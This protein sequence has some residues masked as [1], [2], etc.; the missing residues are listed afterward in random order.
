MR[1]IGKQPRHGGL[2]LAASLVFVLSF[3][4]LGANRAAGQDLG[5]P[6]LFSADEIA[7]DGDTGLVKA[8]GSV[9]VTAGERILMADR[10]TYDERTDTVTAQGNVSVLEA[11]GSVFF[12]DRIELT[13]QLKNGFIDGFRGLLTDN[14]RFAA[15]RAQRTDGNRT[16]MERAVYSPPKD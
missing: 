15:A 9:E 1:C 2:I 11:D 10:V 8:S 14:S 3:A 6:V 5:G 4:G 12:A 13:D 7:Y 16:E